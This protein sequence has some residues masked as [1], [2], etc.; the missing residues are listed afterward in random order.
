VTEFMCESVN[1]AWIKFQEYYKLIDRSVWYTA[2]LVLNP[3]QKWAYLEYAWKDEKDWTTTAKRQF[4]DLWA[5]Y[6]P[7]QPTQPY[8]E[9][10][11]RSSS[12][13]RELKRKESTLTDEMNAWRYVPKKKTKIMDEYDEYLSTAPLEAGAVSNLILWW[14]DRSGQWPNLSRLAFD[15]LSI[16]A[17]SAECERCF[18]DA[19]RTITDERA[20]MGSES[21]EACSCL[22]NWLMKSL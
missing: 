5:Q 17:M 11:A 7:A 12:P 18:S 2:G 4:K 9:A 14:A 8:P 3:E 6:K 16:P 10:A 22:K 19:G 13:S 20:R 1:A 21:I 15:A